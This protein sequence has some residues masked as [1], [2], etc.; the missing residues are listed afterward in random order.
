MTFAD[1]ILQGEHLTAINNIK[2]AVA[3]A[4]YTAKVEPGDPVLTPEAEKAELQ[5]YLQHSS[6]A[7]FRTKTLIARKMMDTAA[8][9]VGRSVQFVG[10]ENLAAVQGGAIVTSN[11]FSPIE[12]LFVRSAARGHR[13]HIVSQLTNLMMHGVLGFLMNYGDTIPLGNRREWV[14]REFPELIHK[15]LVRGQWVLIYPEQEMWFNYRKPRPVQRGAYY[16]AARFNVP[17]VSMFV[18]METTTRK[19]NK[20]FNAIK[21]TVHVLPPIYPDQTLGVRAASIKMAATDYAQKCAAYTAAYGKELDYTFQ[22]SDIAGWQQ[23]G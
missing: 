14:G 18:S 21:Y 11:H 12:N 13:L 1:Q 6:T 8:S 3:A 5:R 17:V 15:C 2:A 16:Y 9:W 22:P 10:R 20:D 7:S 23:K 4:D 19:V